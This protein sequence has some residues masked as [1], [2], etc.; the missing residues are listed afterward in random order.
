VQD[1]LH[2]QPLAKGMLKLNI[3]L[4][5][6]SRQGDAKELAVCVCATSTRPIMCASE[7]YARICAGH[8]QGPAIGLRVCGG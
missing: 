3:G 2:E 5:A 8:M 4:L 1:E 6:A 7:M